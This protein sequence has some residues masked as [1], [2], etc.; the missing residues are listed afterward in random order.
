MEYTNYNAEVDVDRK[1]KIIVLTIITAVVV[2]L[3]AAIILVVVV[4]SSKKAALSGLDD[5]LGDAKSSLSTNSKTAQNK[6]N[7]EKNTPTKSDEKT[8]AGQSNAEKSNTGKSNTGKSGTTQ[9]LSGGAVTQA[10]LPADTTDTTAQQ[11]A[12]TPSTG[13]AEVFSGALGAGALVAATG[14]YLN[15]RKKLSQA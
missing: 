6:A 13:P 15:S 5:G 11:P 1:R 10:V 9:K 3:M 8:G 4:N 2:L 14:Y 12:E 7:P